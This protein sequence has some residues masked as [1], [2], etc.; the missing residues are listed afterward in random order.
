[1]VF[2]LSS[3]VNM[4]NIYDNKNKLTLDQQEELREILKETNKELEEVR[5]RGLK[6]GGKTKKSKKGKKSKTK[7]NKLQ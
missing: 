3:E 6:R 4:Q 7:K 2:L 1:M 5:R